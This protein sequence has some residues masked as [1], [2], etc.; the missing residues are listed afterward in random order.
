MNSSAI[1]SPMTSTVRSRK[2]STISSSRS[3]TLVSSR[4]NPPGR[5]DQVVDDGRR[6]DSGRAS[7]LLE[8]A[9]PG[10]DQ[11]AAGADGRGQLHIDPAI[12]DGIRTRRVDGELADRPVD[13]T[14]PG[15]AALAGTGELG[16]AAVG[17]VR[18]IV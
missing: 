12:A 6:L 11:D 15:L 7:C 18:T 3:W 5:F 17:M 16:D 8:R 9:V 1:R 2:P 4:K 14:A 13:E 10:P